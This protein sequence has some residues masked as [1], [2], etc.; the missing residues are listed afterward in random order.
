M[1]IA[2]SPLSMFGVSRRLSKEV[3][4]RGCGGCDATVNV[5]GKSSYKVAALGA[6]RLRTG[7]LSHPGR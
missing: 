5:N 4:C 3:E 2:I 1:A 7:M 6:V